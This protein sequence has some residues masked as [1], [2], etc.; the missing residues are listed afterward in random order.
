MM[1]VQQKLLSV[2]RYS[3]EGIVECSGLYKGSNGYLLDP[4]GY[5]RVDYPSNC[6]KVNLRY[7]Q[8]ELQYER[9]RAV[10]N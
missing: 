7:E 5:Y 9:I 1:E 3:P 10:N 8:G 6:N 2:T 4:N